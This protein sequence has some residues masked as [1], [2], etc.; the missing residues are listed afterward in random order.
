MY[1]RSDELAQ[2]GGPSAN[3]F[4]HMSVQTV[5]RVSRACM[6]AWPVVND[7]RAARTGYARK[8]GNDISARCTHAFAVITP[9]ALF[10]APAAI[11]RV[12]AGVRVY[13]CGKRPGRDV[14]LEEVESMREEEEERGGGEDRAREQRWKEGRREVEDR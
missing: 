10:L 6:R 9:A 7:A 8:D 1:L 2:I 12:R 13:R 3:R 11:L 14:R 5:A 4:T